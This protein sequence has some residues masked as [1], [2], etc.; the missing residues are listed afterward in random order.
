ADLKEFL[1]SDVLQVRRS[2][3]GRGESSPHIN[4]KPTT[5]LTLVGH[6]MGSLAACSLL[7]HEDDHTFGNGNNNTSFILQHIRGL[8]SIDMPPFVNEDFISHSDEYADE[9]TANNNEDET[10]H[11]LPPPQELVAVLEATVQAMQRVELKNVV[12][13]RTAA[14]ELDA[15]G[16][17]SDPQLRNFLLTNL[18]IP[19]RGLSKDNNKANN[20]SSSCSATWK[21]NIDVLSKS[22]RDIFLTSECMWRSTTTTTALFGSEAH[23]RRV[24]VP[25]LAVMGGRSPLLSLPD[26][27]RLTSAMMNVSRS[28]RAADH[29]HQELVG[30]DSHTNKNNET[31]AEQMRLA[32]Q[33]RWRS[34][35]SNPSQLEW[36]EFE[37]AG[38]NVHYDA[39]ESFVEA[40][41]EFMGKHHR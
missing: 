1:A 3:D 25:V 18:V 7:L 32:Y 13:L 15:A 38:H 26:H 30:V 28:S 41:N 6:S 4:G 36:K 12:D 11:R 22:L 21:P 37:D 19:R 10:L 14:R 20:A 39:L 34:I 31:F 8:V 16:C 24:A 40:T 17:P 35:M 33:C 2:R 29:H 5:P 9:N 27:N 23:R